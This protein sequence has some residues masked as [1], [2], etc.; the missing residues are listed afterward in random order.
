MDYKTHFTKYLYGTMHLLHLKVQPFL[1]P[2]TS[3][4]QCNHCMS[5]TTF[6]APQLENKLENSDIYQGVKAKNKKR[7]KR[8]M[9]EYNSSSSILSMFCCLTLEKLQEQPGSQMVMLLTLC[10]LPAA[11][12]R[13][14]KRSVKG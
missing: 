9:R 8:H 3:G 11:S 7:R 10:L 4:C 2:N 6:F 12:F 13:Y 1:V 14:R 5:T